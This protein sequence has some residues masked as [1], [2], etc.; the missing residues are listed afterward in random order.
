M[1]DPTLQ[2]SEV[3]TGLPSENSSD[4]QARTQPITEA[5]SEVER[6]AELSR[7]YQRLRSQKARKHA[8]VEARVLLNICFA[9]GEQEVNY[10]NNVLSLNPKDENRLYLVFNLIGPRVEKLIG[11]ISSMSAVFKANP[12]RDDPE[13]RADAEVVDKLIRA[14]DQELDQ[15]TKIW[16]ILW[17]MLVGGVAFEHIFWIPNASIELTPATD[18]MGNELFTHTPSGERVPADVMALGLDRGLATPDEFEQAEDATPKGE[19]GSEIL[20]PLNVFI[21][22]SVKSIAEMAPDQ[23][24]YLAKIRTAGWVRENFGYEVEPGQEISIVTSRF[25]QLDAGGTTFLK[26]LIPTIQGSS[27]ANDPGLTVVVEAYGPASEANPSGTYDVFIPNTKLLHSAACPYG[28]IPVVDYHWKPT[29]TSFWNHDYV[30]DLIPAQKFLNK[31]ISQLGEQSNA[32]IY[33]TLLLGA[34]LEAKDIPTDYP[35][36]VKGGIDPNGYE[37]VK[38]LEPPQLPA[39]FLD[40]IQLTKGLLND[41]AGGVDLMQE[42]R[43]PGQ[44]RGPMAVPMLQ[45]ILD[46]Q[47]GPLFSH[48]GERL[49]RSK[50]MRVN[51][52]KQFY[53]PERTMHYVGRTDKDE[54]ME[55]H[56]EKI[57]RSGLSYNITVERGSLVPELRALR[58]AR[59][60]ERLNS[61]LAVLYIDERTGK[62]DKSKIAADLAMGDA[63]RESRESQYRKLGSQIVEMIWQQ[64][65][66]PPVLPFYDHTIMVDEL[67]AAMATTE[68]LKAPP[69]I[70]QAFAARW[71]E[72]RKYMMIEAQQQQAAMAASA[73]HNAVAQASQQAAAQ[74]ASEAVT[75]AMSISQA[76][77]QQPTSEIVAASEA[78][79]GR[80]P[81]GPPRP[82]PQNITNHF[83]APGGQ[84]APR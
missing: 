29:T 8:G 66:V 2:S 63:A 21:D 18:A 12:D 52:V 68:F 30:T 27:D 53:P 55:F 49:A 17:W 43:F 1:S 33:S 37:L 24:I 82:A 78:R 42:Q 58:E 45:E 46:T 47:W 39:W 73:A 59:V 71:E 62:M 51:R 15:P 9:N 5:M 23:R 38:R 69:P 36:A 26:D 7:D 20:G 84:S 83:H 70:Q 60:I 13:A 50:M 3:D 4:S 25:N 41:I 44:I 34:G 65:P 77:K 31:R 22:Q 79:Q 48:L 10:R 64:Q 16:E 72:H 28:E 74:A 75:Q 57:L 80:G 19:V 35:G 11:R 56:T 32:T 67:E 14:L 76:N 54:V 40:S 6:L 81:Q 61:P